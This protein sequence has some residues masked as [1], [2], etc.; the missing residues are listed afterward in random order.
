[1]SVKFTVTVDAD[2]VDLLVVKSLKETYED[3]VNVMLKPELQSWDPL[4]DALT[5]IEGATAMLNYYMLPAEYKKYM[6]YWTDYINK[7]GKTDE[8]DQDTGATD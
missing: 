6:K 4:P 8:E 2:E 7:A 5:R 3:A 1:M